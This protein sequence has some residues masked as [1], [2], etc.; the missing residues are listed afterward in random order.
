MLLVWHV[1]SLAQGHTSNANSINIVRKFTEALVASDPFRTNDVVGQVATPT[2]HPIPT[3]STGPPS[4]SGVGGSRLTGTAC[5]RGS[6]ATDSLSVALG[7][8]F[9]AFLALGLIVAL[10]F[11]AKWQHSR[12]SEKRLDDA[13]EVVDSVVDCFD[14]PE[15][16]I[17]D[18]VEMTLRRP[19]GELSP[20]MDMYVGFVHGV[21]WVGSMEK[22]YAACTC[23]DLQNKCIVCNISGNITRTHY[24]Q[25]TTE[26]LL[27]FKTDDRR[28]CCFIMMF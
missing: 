7:S 9:G 19:S 24:T 6:T 13:E 27:C 14:G 16:M 28:L 1:V 4:S 22:N 10:V 25:P 5:V 3:W 20:D 17:H 18:C 8:T 26:I 12:R 15:M 21:G 2:G 23:P 11:A